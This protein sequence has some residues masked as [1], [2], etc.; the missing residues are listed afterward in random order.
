MRRMFSAEEMFSQNGIL[1][2]RAEREAEQMKI[3]CLF[4]GQGAQYPG[5][6]RD[7]YEKYEK[8]RQVFDEAGEK[9]K[10]LCF[11][12]T[13][14][15][16]KLTENTQPCVYTV[17]MAAYEEFIFRF[18][19]QKPEDAE[20]AAMAG[21]SLGE[22]AAL[23]A[24]GV[25]SDI[26][27]GVELMEHRGRYM[28]EAGRNEAGENI[29][30]MAAAIGDPA[31]VR[32]CVET[33]RQDGILV[34]ANIN[35]PTQTVVSGDRDAVERFAQ[36]AKEARLR[37]TPLSVGSAF[38][39]PMMAPAS[40]KMRQL[41][42]TKK[43]TPCEFPVY[44]NL[45]AGPISEYRKGAVSADTISADCGGAGDQAASENRKTLRPQ[46]AEDIADA[47]ALQLMSPVQWVKIVENLK[48][49]GID[50][51]IEFGP[52]QTLSGLVKKIDKTIRSYNVENA[53][54][55]E[56]ALAEICGKDC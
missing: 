27:A 49:Q 52:G 41:I 18:Q 28:G 5:M 30:T 32:E 38:H 16:L 24:A 7:L 53:E 22:Y 44:S 21:F 33:A 47:M 12:G 56:A 45:T 35:A 29:G 19:E 48:A 2:N 36:V 14:E 8:S 25:I 37:V 50:T 39:S 10:Q 42:L 40:E 4:A 55:L 15:E 3:A 1:G 13:A 46:T 34:A 11:E 43:I 23:T 51:V 31:K 26:P 20:I 6:G 54:S 17:T 9:I